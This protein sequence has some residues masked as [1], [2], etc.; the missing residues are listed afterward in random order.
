[1]TPTDAE[2]VAM[3][4]AGRWLLL[5]APLALIPQAAYAQKQKPPNASAPPPVSA[6][7]D[8]DQPSPP[9][10]GSPSAA[11]GAEPAAAPAAGEAPPA[12]GV[13][14]CQITPDAPQC[15]VAKEI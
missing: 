4:Q 12:G 5:A 10:A 11:P 14:I 2:G 7:A 15:A 13:D 8:A 6:D 1:T 3:K 9:A